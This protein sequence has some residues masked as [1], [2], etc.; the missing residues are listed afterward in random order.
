MIKTTITS[1]ILALFLAALPY[2]QGQ[3]AADGSRART[4]T[5]RYPRML[6]PGSAIARIYHDCRKSIQACEDFIRQNPDEKDFCAGALL[7]MARLYAQKGAKKKAIDV[8][9]KAINDY[10]NE[11]VPDVNATF[12]VKEWALFDIGG[13]ERD[14]GNRDKA[15]QIYGNLMESSNLN[16]RSSS[17]IEYLA[18]KQSHFKLKTR[19]SVS[20]KTFAIGENIPVSVVVLNTEKEA[21][22]FECFIRIRRNQSKSYGAIAPS[23]KAKEIVLKS[24]EEF[25]DTFAFT[26]RDKLEP[27]E[28]EID[29]SLNGIP[30]DTHSEVVQIVKQ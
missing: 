6:I 22:T 26:D 5:H 19:V 14:I 15:L 16:T 30:F 20:K 17:R 18:T 1:V 23:T 3:E 12:T 28:W 27:G 8:Y 9:Q 24:G 2:C 7:H 4:F 13:L 29:C 25:R 11:V 10:G 21:V